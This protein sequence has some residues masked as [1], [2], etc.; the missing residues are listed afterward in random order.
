MPLQVNGPALPKLGPKMKVVRVKTITP[1]LFIV[2][3]D[4]LLT[5]HT[6]YVGRSKECTMDEMQTC[7]GCRL[8]APRRWKGYFD[9]INHTTSERCF[10][11]L[12]PPACKVVELLCEDRAT[13]RGLLLEVSKTKG[14]AQG[15]Y[16]V[17]STNTSIDVATLP[18]PI[19]P[20]P[21]LRVL[22][23]WGTDRGQHA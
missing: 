16:I 2:L 23:E 10:L 21:T 3:S 22:W 1:Q 13:S 9:C 14:G 11:E 15:R 17:R 12:T 18:S 8:G 7:E 6:H 4:K 20:L 19:D 5:V